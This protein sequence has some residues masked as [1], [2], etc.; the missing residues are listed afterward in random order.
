MDANNT[1]FCAG[2]LSNFLIEK[3]T[4]IY[5]DIDLNI[6]N[7]N[8]LQD[9]K[10]NLNNFNDYILELEYDLDYQPSL[11]KESYG[12]WPHNQTFYILEQRFKFTGNSTLFYLKPSRFNFNPP[13]GLVDED[14][15][16]FE[17]HLPYQND[18][19]NLNIVALQKNENFKK[20]I[21]F[22]INSQKND[23]TNFINENMKKIEDRFSLLEKENSFKNDF[24]QGLTKSIK[25]N[26]LTKESTEVPIET[27]ELEKFIKELKEKNEK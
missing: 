11:R 21:D 7:G 15:L 14:F 4:S 17:L 5:D 27:K 25:N 9:I 16:Y 23:V 1:L 12:E 3:F 6:K 10:N 20:D 13:I 19:N 8:T 18:Q 2:C 24:I 26:L 22:F